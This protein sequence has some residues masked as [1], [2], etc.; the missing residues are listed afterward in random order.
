[1]ISMGVTIDPTFGTGMETAGEEIIMVQ[2]SLGGFLA[3]TTVAMAET[4]MAG[5]LQQT[6]L[7]EASSSKE[8]RDQHHDKHQERKAEA[9]GRLLTAR[10]EARK[11]GQRRLLRKGAIIIAGLMECKGRIRQTEVIMIC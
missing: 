10:E 11:I 8:G 9:T 1:M 5:P 6:I 4:I 7:R 3:I 2:G